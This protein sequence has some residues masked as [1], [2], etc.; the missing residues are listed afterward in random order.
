M[1][2]KMA[3]NSNVDYIERILFCSFGPLSLARHGFWII[4]NACQTIE[5]FITSQKIRSITIKLYRPAMPLHEMNSILDRHH[6]NLHFMCSHVRILMLIPNA[7]RLYYLGSYFMDASKL[8]GGK[9]IA[10]NGVS[11][12]RFTRS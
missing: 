1:A 6:F 5:F 12:I 4:K 2:Q 9:M 8:L 3:A 11:L 7:L 10:K